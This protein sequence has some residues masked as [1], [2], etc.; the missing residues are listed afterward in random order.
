MGQKE[1]RTM[2]KKRERQQK[3]IA[4]IKG[5]TTLAKDIVVLIKLFLS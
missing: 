2:K 3:R 1:N 4:I 5:L